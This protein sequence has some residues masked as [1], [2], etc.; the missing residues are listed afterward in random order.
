MPLN[1]RLCQPFF[2]I[3]WTRPWLR[4]ASWKHGLLQHLCFGFPIRVTLVTLQTLNKTSTTKL[5]IN[6]MFNLVTSWQLYGNIP[7]I[8]KY[9]DQNLPGPACSRVCPTYSL[10]SQGCA[11]W[12][13]ATTAMKVE[14]TWKKKQ[15]GKQ[16]S[17]KMIQDVST[18]TKRCLN[19]RSSFSEFRTK[20][21]ARLLWPHQEM[22]KS[23]DGK[24]RSMSSLS[25]MAVDLLATKSHI[26]TQ[27]CKKTIDP[28]VKMVCW[29]IRYLARWSSL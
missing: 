29:K 11:P 10:G 4:T 17:S 27:N 18:V 21:P 13:P 16:R 1:P 7:K 23:I 8:P 12:L 2:C 14:H 6:F 15:R 3:K 20:S 19:F 28:L 24:R 9:H 26:S 25:H 22:E 5:S